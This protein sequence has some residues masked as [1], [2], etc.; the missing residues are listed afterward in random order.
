MKKPHFLVDF[1]PSSSSEALVRKSYIYMFAPFFDFFFL[2][3]FLVCK[4]YS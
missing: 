2:F 1:D 3:L 4:G